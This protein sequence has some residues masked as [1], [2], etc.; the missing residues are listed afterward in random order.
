MC[1][2]TY[3]LHMSVFFFLTQE[4][5]I[6]PKAEKRKI[7]FLVTKRSQKFH[8][9]KYS[10]PRPPNCG[11]FHLLFLINDHFMIF[12][13]PKA[14]KRKRPFLVTKRDQKFNPIRFSNPQPPNCLWVHSLLLSQNEQ[15]LD[16]L[17]WRG[18]PS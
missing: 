1:Y 5:F 8:L 10:E 2:E 15:N 14:D 4:H 3:C 16:F 17:W 11:W 9:K 12:I 13:K 7:Q 6:E 18:G